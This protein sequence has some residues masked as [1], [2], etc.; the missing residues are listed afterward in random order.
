MYVS[1]RHRAMQGF[2]CVMLCVSQ[3]GL[4]LVLHVETHFRLCPGPS[5]S[6][7]CISAISSSCIIGISGSCIGAISGSCIWA[8]SISCIIAISGSC[9][10]A[11]SGSCIIAI[12]S[13][14]IGA[15]SGSCSGSLWMSLAADEL[16]CQVSGVVR[17][18]PL[19]MMF[20]E[21]KWMCDF[22]ACVNLCVI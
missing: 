16:F 6:G 1:Y 19:R 13:S 3:T 9:L 8:V 17:Q 14:C 5:V 22:S 21:L 20:A 18:A 4:M 7:S 10:S 12:S 11:I 2:L 15:I